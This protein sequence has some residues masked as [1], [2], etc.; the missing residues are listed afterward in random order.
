MGGARGSLVVHGR[1]VQGLNGSWGTCVGPQRILVTKS[2]ERS[3]GREQ[4]FRVLR[5]CLWAMHPTWADVVIN[6]C[7]LLTAIDGDGMA[8]NGMGCGKTVSAD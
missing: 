5:A 2:Y 3:E 4:D 6:F 7:F 1:G 8:H